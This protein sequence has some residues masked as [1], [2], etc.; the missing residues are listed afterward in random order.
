MKTLILI[1]CALVLAPAVAS[2]DEVRRVA[3]VV[4]ANAA[5]SGRKPL[6]FAYDDARD[7]EGMLHLAGFARDDI[8]VM[9]DPDPAAI[10][11]TL[12]EALRSFAG[13]PSQL[14]FYY[15][16]HAD[17]QS[18]YPNGKPLDL[19]KLRER[20]DSA[21]ATVRIGIIDACRGGGWTG[22]KGL[23]P[24]EPFEVHLPMQLSN[25]GSVLI[26]SSSGL[27]DAHESEILRGSFFTH[28]WVAGLRGAGDHDNDGSITLGE[29]F[30]YAKE[31]TVRD[32]AMQ[33]TTP[34]H[35]SFQF[36]LRGTNDLTLVTLA[37]TS[38]L[39]VDQTMGPLQLVHLDTGLIVL[40]LPRGKRRMRL[41]LPPGRYLVRRE[42]AAKV[43]AREITVAVGQQTQLVEEELT[44]VGTN[45]LAAK[46]TDSPN[47]YVAVG[48]GG[49]GLTGTDTESFSSG[50]SWTV[51]LGYRVAPHLHA[52]FNGDYTSF[53]RYS[54]DHDFSQ[55]Q[56]ALTLGVR[57]APFEEPVSTRGSDFTNLYL[58]AALGAGHLIR[59]RYGEFFSVDQGAWGPAATLGVGWGVTRS[60]HFGL[61]VEA[62]DSVVLYD[63]D[64][65][66]HN[67][68]FNLVVHAAL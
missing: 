42:A 4:G 17:T 67:V 25:E 28:H 5:P 63:G 54:L 9:L 1:I 53:T 61:A 26:A 50:M 23:S 34:Q 8:H 27:E 58:K 35:P 44:L 52:L 19:D 48:A 6:R 59:Q 2:A 39:T 45:Q 66:R 15:S 62:S 12:D 24:T 10:L 11:A 68:G 33:T 32:T 31:L 29:A 56:A 49:G 57:W 40:E 13:K 51:Q 14:V 46:G 36:N 60:E 21:R 65:L 37:G 7:I 41:A 43:Y 38:L 22:T 55:Q 30:A 20:L 64:T 16:G 47:L 3:I 18:L